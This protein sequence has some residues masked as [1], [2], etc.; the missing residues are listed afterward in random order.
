MPNVG[1]VVINV[2]LKVDP[3]DLDGPDPIPVLDARLR[4]L[5]VRAAEDAGAADPEGYSLVALHQRDRE[6]LTKLLADAEARYG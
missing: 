3:Y 4:E 2:V 6:R 1:T 5:V